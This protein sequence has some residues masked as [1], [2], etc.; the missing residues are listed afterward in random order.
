MLPQKL[1]FITTFYQDLNWK[2]RLF[3]FFLLRI[4]TKFITT[5]KKHSFTTMQPLTTLQ[6]NTR[7]YTKIKFKI[8]FIILWINK[9]RFAFVEKLL[10]LD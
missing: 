5:K 1:D 4:Y 7:D 10:D 2:K 9:K 3:F 6:R 8:C